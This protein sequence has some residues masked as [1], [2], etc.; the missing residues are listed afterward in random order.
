MRCPKCDTLVEPGDKFCF[1]CG[2]ALTCPEASRT[3]PAD[4]PAL[5]CLH[6]GAPLLDKDAFCGSCGSPAGAEPPAR[7]TAPAPAPRPSPPAPPSAPAPPPAPA[8]KQA[9]PHRGTIFAGY[10]NIVI[11]MVIIAMARQ[12]L[13]TGASGFGDPYRPY[14]MARY[15]MIGLAAGML[16]FG[17]RLWLVKNPIA[18]RH[19]RIIFFLC[20]AGLAIGFLLFA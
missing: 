14:L 7:R 18:R 12:V 19:G 10:L 2:T 13:V 6:C 15:A 17:L 9:K 16:L 20:L 4:R 3:A 8:I 11:W 1:S 5:T